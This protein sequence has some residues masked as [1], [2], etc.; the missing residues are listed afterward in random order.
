MED[1]TIFCGS[2][3]TKVRRQALCKGTASGFRSHLHEKY[4]RQ[5]ILENTGT[6]LFKTNVRINL[7]S[8]PPTLEEISK[9]YTRNNGFDYSENFDGVQDINGKKI[10]INLKS[11]VGKGGSQT[12]SLKEVY[13]FIKGQLGIPFMENVFFANVLDGDE[14]TNALKYFNFLVKQEQPAHEPSSLPHVFIGDLT[15]YIDWF[16]TVVALLPIDK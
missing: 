1:H 16:N 5:K 8:S 7:R 9:P 4:Q 12:R 11:I 2:S 6:P 10:Y 15:G 3:V 13:W 14:A